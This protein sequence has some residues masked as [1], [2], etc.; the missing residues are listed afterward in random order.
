MTPTFKDSTRKSIREYVH[1]SIVNRMAAKGMTI[2]VLASWSGI[3]VN[4][5]SD[6]VLEAHNPT[7]DELAMMFTALGLPLD[8]LVEHVKA[9]PWFMRHDVVQLELVE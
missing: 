4:R 1:D 3:T 9:M 2:D 8:Y 7:F 5:V 6:I